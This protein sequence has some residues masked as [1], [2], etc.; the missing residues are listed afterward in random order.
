M[1]RAISTIRPKQALAPNGHHKKL[2]LTFAWKDL[3]TSST[4]NTR[5]TVV[6]AATST[7]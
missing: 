7:K 1:I 5:K 4:G 2:A 3:A 6:A